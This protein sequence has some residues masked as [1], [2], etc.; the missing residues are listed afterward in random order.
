MPEDQDDSTYE[1]IG[2][3]IN[4]LSSNEEMGKLMDPIVEG[5][6][7]CVDGLK[8]QQIAQL[9]NSMYASVNGSTPVLTAG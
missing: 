8:P 2:N 4:I 9:A 5:E 6:C 7:R 1:K 3:L